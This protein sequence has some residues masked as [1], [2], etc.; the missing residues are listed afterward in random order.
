MQ[1]ASTQLFT[2]ALGSLFV[3]SPILIAWM[4]GL[5]LAFV[6]WKRQPRVALF[7]AIGFGLLLFVNIIH[8][9]VNPLL[10]GWMIDQLGSGSQV[11]LILSGI[12]C[13]VN[14]FE[15]AAWA[16]IIAA[17]FTARRQTMPAIG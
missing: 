3:M 14:L 11:S 8:A 2:S 4:V 17:I 12:T 13:V 16:L 6:F 10:F 7:A 5:V 15:A 9:F 1:F